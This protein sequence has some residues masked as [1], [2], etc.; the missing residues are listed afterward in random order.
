MDK[1]EQINEMIEAFKDAIGNNALSKYGGRRMEAILMSIQP[2]W[3]ELICN[4]KKTVEVR[5]TAPKDTPFKVYI[6]QTKKRWIYKLLPWLKKRQAKAIGEFVCD[7]I[8]YFPYR[9][10][11]YWIRLENLDKTCLCYG[12]LQN[13]GK[14]KP[15]FGLHISDLKIYD[16]PKALGEFITVKCTNKKGS[17]SDCKI[18]PDC[19]KYLTRPPQSWQYVEDIGQ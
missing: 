15:L 5:K 18:K 8:N 1:Q 17:C 13:Y 16:E 2:K 14:G 19:I 11:T 10:N 3:C 12:E 9:L 7:K 4:G 6:Y